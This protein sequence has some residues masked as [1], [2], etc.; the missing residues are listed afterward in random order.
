VPRRHAWELT[1]EVPGS[2]LRLADLAVLL[3]AFWAS[4]QLAPVL[5]TFLVPGG[6]LATLIEAL[7]VPSS[8]GG[9]DLLPYARP[10]AVLLIVVPVA[11]LTMWSLGGYD[12]LSR[13]S[14][15]RVAMSSLLAAF[16][17]VSALTL[18]LF[19]FRAQQFSRSFVL[20]YGVMTAIGFA[21]F[22]FAVRLYKHRRAQ[23]GR[24][25]RQVAVV[26]DPAA[27]AWMLRYFREHASPTAVHVTGYFDV[28]LSEGGPVPHSID[29]VERLERIERLGEVMV[30]RPIH[31]VVAV[32]GPSASRWIS[33]VTQSCDY[34]GIPLRIVPGALLSENAREMRRHHFLGGTRLPEI[35]LAPPHAHSEQL[36]VKRLVD[37]FG[38]SVLLL[39]CL[40]LFGLIAL[41]IKLS[42]PHLPVFY[43]WRV[44]GYKGLPFTGYKFTTMQ[45]DADDQKQ[46]LLDRNEMTGPV[47]K[48]RHDPR[49]TPLGRILRKFSLNELP[50][51]WSVLRGDMSLVGP[52]PAFPHELER[53]E[54][55]HKRKLCVR[56]GMTCLWQVRGRNR[57]NNFD[58]WVRMDLEY[59]DQW[60]LWL[61]VKILIRT[62]WAVI[63]GTGS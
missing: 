17:G 33:G 21:T 2:F 37:I 38:A 22:R 39:L 25:A 8:L 19:T 12:A 47:F 43:K 56:P 11:T 44:I 23:S 46:E 53:Y 27:V 26:G 16:A 51:L 20:L 5:Q 7:R 63:A 9:S 10:L 4:A 31:E 1:A 35:V 50:Q 14:R 45:A 41:G 6:A 62:V 30:H 48:I 24:Y 29:G 40:P 49:V 59:I 28:G 54:L 42:T 55:W 60:S 36:F 32:L 18:V 13:Q 57:V 52:R 15:T 58:D 34:F 61:D 3:S